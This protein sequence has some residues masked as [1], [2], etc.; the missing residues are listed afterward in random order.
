MFFACKVQIH[1]NSTANP[2]NNDGIT[3][4]D[5]SDEIGTDAFKL[6]IKASRLH[7]STSMPIRYTKLLSTGA[8][9]AQNRENPEMGPNSIFVDVIET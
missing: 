1:C 3:Q 4:L 9:L 6:E 2:E 7:H 5:I 8:F